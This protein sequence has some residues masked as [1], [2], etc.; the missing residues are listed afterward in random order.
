MGVAVITGGGAFFMVATGGKDK[1]GSV[2]AAIPQAKQMETVRVLVADQTFE[3][4]TAIDPALTT[5]LKWPADSVPP[6]LITED[7]EEFYESLSSRRARTTIHEG[8]PIIEAKTVQQGDS[9]LM[10]ALLTPGMRA[11]SA[12]LSGDSTTSGFV[13]PGDRVDII[14]TGREGAETVTQTILSNVRVIAIDQTLREEGGPNSIK[15]SS[16]TFELSPS[17]VRPFLVAREGKALTLVLRSMF[18][19]EVQERKNES[20]S[21][22]IVLRYGQG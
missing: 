7:D 14:A 19:G 18:D 9:G 6:H 8:E 17:E 12:N 15:G 3:R 4:G 2:Q 5:W 21:E 10:A 16:V 20:S 11:I 1:A 22:V 13:L